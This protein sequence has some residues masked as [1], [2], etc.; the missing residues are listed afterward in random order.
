MGACRLGNF[1]FFQVHNRAT[2]RGKLPS[3][4][5]KFF[6]RDVGMRVLWDKRLKWMRVSGIA[7]IIILILL[8]LF[9]AFTIYGNKVGNFV[10]NV[11]ND[12]EI[13]LMLSD[14]EDL[15][16]QTPRLVYS[17]V[18]YLDHNT[19]G[20]LPDD[21]TSRGLGN[22]SDDNGGAFLAYSF[23]LINNSSH[24]LDC[25]MDLTLI[26]TVGDPMGMI[27]VMLIEE[28]NG[29]FDSSNRIYALTESSPEREQE[30]R[31]ELATLRPYETEPFLL[32]ESKLFSVDFKDFAA[33]AHRRFT[34]VLWLEGCDRDC[35]NTRL[36][37]RA[38]MQID[39]T[40]Y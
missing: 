32:A 10:I 40:G 4:K 17:S 26:D 19:Y 13:S 27:R 2:E 28:E 12:G 23:Y 34:V 31:E 11:G 38:K 14:H 39:I 1:L 36:G 22:V 7:I 29:T 35:N 8:L 21:I 37:S 30:M 24:A 6:L 3:R 25:T 16:E 15:S 9:A 18:T 20:W 5:Q 33:G